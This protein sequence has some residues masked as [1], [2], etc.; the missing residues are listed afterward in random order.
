MDYAEAGF[1]S[2]SDGASLFG[3]LNL[4][5]YFS[6]HSMQLALLALQGVQYFW[7]PVSESLLGKLSE[8]LKPVV[9]MQPHVHRIGWQAHSP[10]P[11]CSR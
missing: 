6:K 3:G 5:L 10:N 4:V 1:H 7:H 8:F 9:V 2:D 11:P